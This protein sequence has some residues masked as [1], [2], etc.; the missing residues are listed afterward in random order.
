MNKSTQRKFE[1]FHTSCLRR[2]LCFSYLERVTNEEVL[3]RSRISTLSAMIM[4]KRLKWFG[5]VLRMNDDRLA[6]HSSPGSRQKN[7]DMLNELQGVNARR[8]GINL[9]KIAQGTT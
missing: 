1:S 6:L 7:I 3:A 2:I 5:H 8:G 4:I 9:K